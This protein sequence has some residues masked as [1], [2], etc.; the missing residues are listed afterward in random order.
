MRSGHQSD[1]W[2]LDELAR[3]PRVKVMA[4]CHRNS[5]ERLKRRNWLKDSLGVFELVIIL[6]RRLGTGTI[7]SVLRI[8]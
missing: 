1:G 7:E 8:S 6:S 4:T 2:I 3:K 5:W